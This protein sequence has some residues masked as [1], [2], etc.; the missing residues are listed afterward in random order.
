[1]FFK[2]KVDVEDYC[3]ANLRA[4]FE[5]ERETTYELLRQSCADP[6]LKAADQRL[7]LDHIRAI[8]IELLRI[9][10]VKNCK[11]DV[12]SDAGV[13]VMTYLREHRL[14][15]LHELG[16]IYSKAFGGHP[17]DGVAGIVEAFSAAVTDSQM[18][19]ATMERFHTELYGILNVF[20][21]D[22]QVQQR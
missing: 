4:L 9:A 10:I 5:F 17:D 1:M 21:D 15:R 22:L 11:F 3:A 7:Y 8:V 2:K 20:F 12:S 14:S 16:S 18:S 19:Q 13:F 6:A